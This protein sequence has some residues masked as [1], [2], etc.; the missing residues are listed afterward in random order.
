MV[1][2]ILRMLLTA[3]VTALKPWLV[4][5]PKKSEM[6]DS[7]FNIGTL[8]KMGGSLGHDSAMLIFRKW[9][10]Y[11]SCV[12]GYVGICQVNHGSYL[13]IKLLKSSKGLWL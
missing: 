5:G 4:S 6:F 13:I 10:S 7:W 9:D 2:C 11:C 12:K 3:G 1:T 8:K